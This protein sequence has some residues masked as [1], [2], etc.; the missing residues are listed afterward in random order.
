MLR[1]VSACLKVLLTEVILIDNVDFTSDDFLTDAAAVT[2]SLKEFHCLI[3]TTNI[4]QLLSNLEVFLT[5]WLIFECK[6]PF[7][8]YFS[9]HVALNISH[10]KSSIPILSPC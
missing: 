1:L 8:N 5:D 9:A 10:N 4:L 7:P 2:N 6:E 3:Y